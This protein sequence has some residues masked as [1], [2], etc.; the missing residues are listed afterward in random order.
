MNIEETGAANPRRPL[1]LWP[2]VAAAMLLLLARFGAPI[3]VPSAAGSEVLI[4]L[5]GGL[6][7][8]LWWMF[9]S[10]A[11][12]FERVGAVAFMAGALWATST[13]VHESIAGGAM[14]MLLYL[15]AVPVLSLALVAW[16]VAGQRLASG[17]RWAALAASVVLACGVLTSIRTDGVRGG[18]FD[19]K[20]R[21]TTTSEERL[22]AGTRHDPPTGST[23]PGAEVL[24]SPPSERGHTPRAEPADSVRTGPA[25]AS[26]DAPQ[27]PAAA[28]DDAETR[29][30]GDHGIG[31]PEWP[32]FRGPDRNGVVAAVRID[33]D[34]AKSPPIELWRRPIGPGWSSFA[35]W[36]DRLYT[37]EQRGDEEIVACYDA[38]TGEALWLHRNAARFW[39]SNGGP[40]PRATPAVSRGRVFALGAT[41]I[42]NA[43]DAGDGSAL[44]ARNASSD[45]ETE[46]PYWGMSASPLVIDELVIVAASGRL[47]AYDFATGAPRWLGPEGGVSYS[48]PHPTTIDG[49]AQVL[50]QR[51]GGAI[52]VALA[53]GTLLWEHA[54]EGGAI[55]QPAMTSEGDVLISVNGMTGGQGV[56]RLAVG[57]GPDGWTVR[58]R[59]TSRGLKPYFNDFVLHRGHA[60]GFDG[61]IL[62]CVD[63]E[64]G[65]RRWKNGRYGHGQLVLLPD[66]DLLL[67]LSEDG[68]LA[69][70][71]ATPD[72]FT[73]VARFPA[74][75]GKTW[76]H[77]VVVGDVL[78]VRNGQEMA[79]F[80]LPP[81]GG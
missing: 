42:V 1:R 33:T 47:V 74:L 8:V 41:G 22:L 62:A 13:V 55:V 31:R 3:V 2:G 51:A 21:W 7:I 32:G 38:A 77:P 53:D 39:E 46:V 44:W 34:W 35:V 11:P 4:G 76:N 24:P 36:G 75:E 16:A 64:N 18:D 81:A 29:A 63:L 65:A 73:E 66:Q 9:F 80:R 72:G 57:S 15:L 10:R 61:H 5:A 26:V 23:A 71:R 69:L 54:W 19:F 59:W 67:V 14:G 50:F 60:F 25:V 68:E 17:P 37:Q 79:A 6:M 43:L 20:W 58:E 56:R 52:S 78:L 30:A 12:W 40:G 49:I 45:A 70:V 27:A 48:S 28:N